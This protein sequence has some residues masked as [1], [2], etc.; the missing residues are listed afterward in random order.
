MQLE[1]RFPR[2]D[3]QRG[4][5]GGRTSPRASSGRRHVQL[6]YIDGD[7]VYDAG[8]GLAIDAAL[9]PAQAGRTPST[10]AQPSALRPPSGSPAPGRQRALRTSRSRRR[11][12]A[13]PT[14]RARGYL[15]ERSRLEEPRQN[16]SSFEGFGSS[17]RTGRSRRAERHVRPLLLQPAGPRHQPTPRRPWRRI[18]GCHPGGLVC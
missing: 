15:A 6:T 14:G 8:V 17:A 7:V 18:G 13:C 16:R 2:H 3:C 12:R 10:S 1:R 9:A 11:Q 4:D 5:D